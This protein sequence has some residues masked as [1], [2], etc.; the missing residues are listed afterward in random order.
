[1]ATRRIFNLEHANPAAPRARGSDRQFVFMAVHE[2]RASLR[3]VHSNT[4]MLADKFN[5]GHPEGAA[6]LMG[7]IL[8][9]VERLEALVNDIAEYCYVEVT[10][11]RMAKTSV[12]SVV[13]E[14]LVE[15][16]EEIRQK[17]AVVTH[18]PLPTI[19][20]DFLS[21][22]AVFRILIDNACKFRSEATPRIH[23]SADRQG[24]NWFFSVEDNGI[25]F[26]PIYCE[27]VFEP[28]E[29]LNG[30]RYPGTGLGLYVGRRI[31]KL[32]DGVIWAESRSGE[33]SIFR[34][35]LP[36]LDADE[37]PEGDTPS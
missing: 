32:H 25:G 21:L 28:F 33:G 36:A 3:A 24:G 18:D 34:F 19:Q 31:L 20:C 1:M 26:D 37:S 14:A 35:S 27:R 15:L 5:A 16:A 7:L 6:D 23:I 4:G 29:R 17:E 9:G 30:R 13:Q 8:A 10:D 12:D 2:L 11:L 22:T